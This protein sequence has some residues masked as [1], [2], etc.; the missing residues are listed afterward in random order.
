MSCRQA[1]ACG[2]S[3]L[4]SAVTSA[5]NKGLSV[6][7]GYVAALLPLFWHATGKNHCHN[8]FGHCLGSKRKGSYA[9][10]Y[11]LCTRASLHDEVSPKTTSSALAIAKAML[12]SVAL[13]HNCVQQ[14]LLPTPSTACSKRKNAALFHRLRAFAALY[15]AFASLLSIECS[16]EV[17]R[18][19]ALRFVSQGI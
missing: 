14:N 16:L 7:P 5:Q 2:V 11:L 3:A 4:L 17:Y 19:S 6:H 13:K 10:G 9:G 18:L 1:T 12:V 8:F 15:V